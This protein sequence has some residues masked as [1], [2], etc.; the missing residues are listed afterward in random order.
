MG[1]IAAIT[2]VNQQEIVVNTVATQA[3]T[4]PVFLVLLVMLILQHIRLI[5]FRLGD[6]TRKE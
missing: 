4:S 2:L 1:V 3:V 6:K 5:M